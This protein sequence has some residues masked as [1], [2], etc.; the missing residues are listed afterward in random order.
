MASP[1]HSREI[2]QVVAELAEQVR[3]IESRRAGSGAESIS[4][5][6]P[7]LDR[8]LPDGGFRRGTLVE[9]LSHVCGSNVHSSN[10]HSSNVC[11]SNV[12][13]SNVCGSNVGG[14][15]VG[16]SNVGGSNVGGS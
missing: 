15:N 10:V 7:R 13:G 11:G 8:L 4:S 3:Q 2:P 5:G 9:W 1:L 14:S 16:G 12:C 6:D